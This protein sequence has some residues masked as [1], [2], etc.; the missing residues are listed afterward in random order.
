M[1]ETEY[2]STRSVQWGQVVCDLLVDRALPRWPQFEGRP[3][4]PCYQARVGLWQLCR[5]WGLK[6]D[7]EVLLPAYNCGS[8]VDPFLHFG[9]VAKMY[10]V[11][12]DTRIYIEDLCR[13]CTARTRV[14]YITHYF[15]WPQTVKPIYEWCTERGIRVVEDCALSLFSKGPEGFLG[16]VGD[17]AV[18][19]FRKTLSVPDGGAVVFREA[20][21]DVGAEVS[22]RRP[23][24]SVTL[25]NLLPFAKAT[26]LKLASDVGMYPQL[27]ALRLRRFNEEVAYEEK[28]FPDM[29]S[30]YYFD[31]RIQNWNM[32]RTT[33]GILSHIDPEVVVAQRRRNYLVLQN[34]V[35][36]APGVR[37]LF[38][39]LPEGVCPL[40]LVLL[41]S[42]RGAIVRAL[43]AH[44]IA[45]FPWWEG[46]HRQF[47][48][49]EFPD[50]CYLKD[51]ALMLP[52]N[53]TLKEKHMEY[54]AKCFIGIHSEVNS[55]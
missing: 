45:A 7:D 4:L 51:H 28:P 2:C 52:V 21:P 22:M 23:P 36:D 42:R 27:R 35:K 33:L 15:G 24:L 44:G 37:V 50:A 48:C 31:K 11:G 10:R 30:D 47:D 53:H 3:A 32:S 49:R 12:T 17:A 54:I 40:G 18:F 25:A 41:V 20:G 43:N 26:A 38:S 1:R 13:R 39:S 5:H 9:L 6:Q 19:S 34:L 8:E 29:P 46:Y 14:V 16:T 55:K